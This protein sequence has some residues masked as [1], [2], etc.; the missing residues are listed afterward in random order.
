VAAGHTQAGLALA[1]GGRWRASHA[2]AC[3]PP[4][5]QGSRVENA[6]ASRTPC[7]L[8]TPSRPPEKGNL[9]R[10]LQARR[11]LASAAAFDEPP[12]C[13]PCCIGHSILHS[14]PPPCSAVSE[15]FTF[16]FHLFTA[17]SPPPSLRSFALLYRPVTRSLIQLLLHSLYA[18]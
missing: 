4:W 15:R 14:S 7:P 12:L 3:T 5:R 8:E 11:R 10:S 6:P 17:P 13:S 2:P 9:A 18:S 1:L 16:F